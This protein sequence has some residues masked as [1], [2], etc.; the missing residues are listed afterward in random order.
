MEELRING[1]LGDDHPTPK[2]I[3]PNTELINRIISALNTEKGQ[4]LIK[5]MFEKM[6]NAGIIKNKDDMSQAKRDFV[7]YL[8]YSVPEFWTILSENI[9]NELQ[10]QK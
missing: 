7:L 3:M 4:E 5:P 8:I 1:G 2:T 10:A 9:Y 6:Y